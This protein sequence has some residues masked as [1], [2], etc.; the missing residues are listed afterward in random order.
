MAL[1]CSYK[2][3]FAEDNF[4]K[5]G[6]QKSSRPAARYI[7]MSTFDVEQEDC[8]LAAANIPHPSLLVFTCLLGF[9][10]CYQSFPSDQILIRRWNRQSNQ[11]KFDRQ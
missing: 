8:S 7:L 4:P 6:V 2:K 5:Y 9:L 3:Y 11:S 1:H 10:K